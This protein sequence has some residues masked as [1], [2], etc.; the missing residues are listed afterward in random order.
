VFGSVKLDYKLVLNVAGV[1][2]FA[3]LMYLTVRRGAAD[4]VCGMRVDRH[5]AL[6]REVAG[7]TRYFCSE[8][9]LD[10]FESGAESPRRAE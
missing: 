2:V 7:R 8:H 4:P 10:V 6:H 5:R 9:C 3:A 1:L